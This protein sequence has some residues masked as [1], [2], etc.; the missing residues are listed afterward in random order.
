MILPHEDV[1]CPLLHVRTYQHAAIVEAET[2]LPTDTEYSATFILG[3]SQVVAGELGTQESLWYSSCQRH[4]GPTTN[5]SDRIQR[6]GKGQSV[7]M[8]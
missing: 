7:Q 1:V 2:R 5:V 4:A 3:P 8:C 6:Q